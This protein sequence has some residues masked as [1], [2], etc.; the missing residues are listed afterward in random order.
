MARSTPHLLCL[1]LSI[2]VGLLL[3]SGCGSGRSTVSGE[4]T[5]DGQP[6]DSGSIVFLPA[7]GIGPSRGATI[8]NGKFAFA[9]AEAPSPGKKIVKITGSMKTGR[10]VQAS[11]PAP[12]GMMIDEMIYIK[13]PTREAEI[14][15]QES[16]PLSFAISSAE[17]K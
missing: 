12:Q 4:V 1:S 8:E 13:P 3:I 16:S 14:T 5:F 6:L 2:T 15:E 9:A 10:Q 7:D 11:A 17:L